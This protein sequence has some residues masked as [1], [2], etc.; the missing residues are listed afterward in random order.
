MKYEDIQEITKRWMEDVR[1]AKKYR[2]MQDMLEMLRI[3]IVTGIRYTP[4]GKGEA[5]L[6]IKS[7]DGVLLYEKAKP[8]E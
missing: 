3:D 1:A 7:I 5:Y 4:G 8:Y 6:N 2:S